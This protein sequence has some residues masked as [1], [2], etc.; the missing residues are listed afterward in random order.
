MDGRHVENKGD[1]TRT[2]AQ[3]F[4]IRDAYAGL[5]AKESLRRR[6]LVINAMRVSAS[7]YMLELRIT[8]ANI[9]RGRW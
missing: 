6:R 4:A 7:E 5:A 3:Q 8:E 9:R 1:V 2:Y